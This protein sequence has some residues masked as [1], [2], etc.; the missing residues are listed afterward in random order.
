MYEM[1]PVL[2]VTTLPHIMRLRLLVKQWTRSTRAGR[3]LGGPVSTRHCGLTEEKQHRDVTC[4]T[5]NRS[6]FTSLL[7]TPLFLLRQIRLT[8]GLDD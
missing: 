8:T 3:L 2:T 4:C 5:F 6:H 7:L 1:M